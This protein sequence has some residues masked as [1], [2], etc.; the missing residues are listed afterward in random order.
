MSRERI[1]KTRRLVATSWLATDVEDLSVVHSDAET[2]R[3][4]RHGRPETRAETA[5]LIGQYVTEHTAWG[6]TKWRLADLDGRLVGRA[7]FGTLRD[8]RELGY[9]I[10]RE[11]WGQG[12]ATE[13]GAALV[14]WHLTNAVQYPLYA[15]VAVANLASRRVVEKIGFEFVGQEDHLGVQCDLFR[16]RPDLSSR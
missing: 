15:H 8:G 7:G 13:I 5:D 12:L 10:R 14:T 11:L 6:F 3:F 4:V 1:L 2:M 9:T 16:I